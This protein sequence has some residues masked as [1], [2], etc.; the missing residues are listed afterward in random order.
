MDKIIQGRNDDVN[1]TSN[2]LYKVSEIK[3]DINSETLTNLKNGDIKIISKPIQSASDSLVV[4]LTNKENNFQYIIK[5]TLD[6]STQSISGPFDTEKE[7]YKTMKNI[8]KNRLTPHIYSFIDSK[9]VS[10]NDLDSNSKLFKLI[11][12]YKTKKI[13][14]AGSI[15]PLRLNRL[16]ILMNETSVNNIESLKQF[17]IKKKVMNHKYCQLILF[18]ILFQIMYTLHIFNIHKIKHNDLHFWKYINNHVKTE[19]IRSIKF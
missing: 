15:L 7:N 6:Y 2:R 4:K 9:S 11:K 3:I 5:I 13:V 8:L 1:L 16:N 12:P 10:I 17:L 14:V 18:N 19:Y